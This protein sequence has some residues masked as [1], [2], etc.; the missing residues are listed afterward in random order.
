LTIHDT[1]LD[2]MLL[3]SDE[4]DGPMLRWVAPTGKGTLD[5]VRSDQCVTGDRWYPTDPERIAD[6]QAALSSLGLA[7]GDVVSVRGL[8][9]L[10]RRGYLRADYDV[11][12]IRQKLLDVTPRSAKRVLAEP[13]PYQA[14]G[15]DFLSLISRE[16]LGAILGDEMGLGKTLQAIM[17]IA[18][19]VD[20]G[21]RTNLVVAPATLL[22]NWMIELEKFA[23]WI[24][25]YLHTGAART[26][27]A[28]SLQDHDV[29]L[30]TYD[31]VANDIGV[32]VR[33]AWNV[34][35]LDEAQHVK[36]A[37]TKR[38]L[39][40]KRLP[41]RV[42][43]AV[44]GTPIENTLNDLTSLSAFVLPGYL[45]EGLGGVDSRS[46]DAAAELSELI[47]PIMIR[48]RVAEV[49]RDLPERIDRF[50]PLVLGPELSDRYERIRE[51]ALASGRGS[52]LAALV[53]LRQFC[54]FPGLV[55]DQFPSYVPTPKLQALFDILA[56]IVARSGKVLVFTSFL[57]SED[58]VLEVAKSAGLGFVNR[59]DG[60][61]PIADRQP[62]V[63]AFN[64]SP[65]SACLVINPKAGGAGLN[66]QGAN[67][68]IHFNPE[69]NPA[70]QDQ[71]S[72]RAYRRGQSQVVTVHHLYYLGTVE[73]V[74]MDRLLEKRR[75][76]DVALAVAERQGDQPDIARALSISPMSRG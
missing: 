52:G 37:G 36:N 6:V 24:D 56:E 16:S 63:D 11:E 75:L 48:R 12:L 1:L 53:K 40:V 57:G 38:S 20:A 35:T 15:F 29:V 14:A 43:L 21:R 72:A 9:E 68:V 76:S 17:L 5:L 54:C 51:D 8:L 47:A 13:Y 23:P 64:Q 22:G 44:T 7:L 69:W 34:V 41:R 66:L 67:H 49:A 42:S 60:S 33:V 70:T 27:V 3:V 46:L 4:S 71:A 32:F 62:L 55:D 31:T 30:T 39:A 19:E 18:A 61:V 10:R 45:E 50:V 65:T 58:V 25:V 74:V 59:I 28:A 73:E 26:G 2:P